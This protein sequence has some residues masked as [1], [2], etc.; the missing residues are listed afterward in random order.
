MVL[1]ES[2]STREGLANTRALMRGQCG[3]QLRDVGRQG[4]DGLAFHLVPDGEPLP[5][6]VHILQ[7]S[8]SE[9]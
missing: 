9:G 5:F 1:S 4:N 2:F 8:D 6:G 3:Q 7:R